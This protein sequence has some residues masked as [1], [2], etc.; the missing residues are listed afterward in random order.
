MYDDLLNIKHKMYN[1]RK[2]KLFLDMNII[3]N[4]GIV[5]S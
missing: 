4:L 3:I 1:K 5:N 2:E